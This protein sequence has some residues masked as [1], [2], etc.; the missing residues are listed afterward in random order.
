MVETLRADA[1][2]PELMPQTLA[3]AQ[4][5][6]CLQAERNYA[7]AHTT[8]Y[9]VFSFL[10]GLHPYYAEYVAD[11]QRAI[12]PFELLKRNGYAIT[13]ASSSKLAYYPQLAGL[14]REFSGYREF[15]DGPDRDRQLVDWFAASRAGR[16]R[17]R[18]GYTFLFFYT[19]HHN[20]Y[21]PPQF[22]RYTP[23]LPFDYDHFRGDAELGRASVEIHNRYR[24]SVL[25]FDSLLAETLASVRAEIDAGELAVVITGDHG[26]EFWEHGLLGHGQT[27]F[28]NERV[29]TPLLV[30]LPGVARRTVPLTSHVDVWPTLVDFLEPEPAVD[31]AAYFSGVSLTAAGGREPYALVSGHGFPYRNPE[32]AL[33]TEQGKLWLAKETGGIDRENRFRVVRATD[34]LDRDAPQLRQRLEPALARLRREMSRFVALRD[35][36]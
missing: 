14:F 35:A 36:R 32:A 13:G 11:S 33:V 25:Y 34:L 12:F 29:Q 15:V 10:S 7:A 31:R 28:E 1:L 6:G 4:R 16:E 27:R 26:E 2:T 18:P 9:S 30:C 24:N 8:S 21:Y 19:P 5:A 22:E 23:V 17:G 20:Y 3:F